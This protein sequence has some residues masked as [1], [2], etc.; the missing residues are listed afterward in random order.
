LLLLRPKVHTL[1]SRAKSADFEPLFSFPSAYHDREHPSHKCKE[2]IF[3]ELLHGKRST[4]STLHLGHGT[5]SA[6]RREL[7]DAFSER[8]QPWTLVYLAAAGENPAGAQIVV[9][10]LTN[11]MTL[12]GAH[13]LTFQRLAFFVTGNLVIPQARLND[14]TGQ[15]NDLFSS[16]L[17]GS[18]LCWN[19]NFSC[20]CNKVS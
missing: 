12:S 6:R 7:P 2:N 9:T 17:R 1:S 11:L 14:Q 3:F 5:W 10:N 15:S 20:C 8:A 16:T 13:D 19:R 18:P 4:F